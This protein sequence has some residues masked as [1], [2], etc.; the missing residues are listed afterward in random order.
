MESFMQQIDTNDLWFAVAVLAGILVMVLVVL[1]AQFRWE[2]NWK[3]QRRIIDAAWQPVEYPD[4]ET[5]AYLRPEHGTARHQ[6][7]NLPTTN[8][9]AAKPYNVSSVVAPPAVPKPTVRLSDV[10]TLTKRS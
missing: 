1:A 9:V 5:P 3:R 6:Y 7:G 4:L 2:K 8:P 10:Y